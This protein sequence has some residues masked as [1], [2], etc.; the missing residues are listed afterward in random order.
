[1]SADVAVPM[2]SATLAT[3]NGTTTPVPA[4]FVA[5]I[6]TS[7][8]CEVAAAKRDDLVVILAVELASS[9][10]APPPGFEQIDAHT[11]SVESPRIGRYIV[12]AIRLKVG[13]GEVAGLAVVPSLAWPIYEAGGFYLR[14]ALDV[15][16]AAWQARRD[17]RRARA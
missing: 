9:D 2:L 17:A 14:G 12:Q 8:Y 5:D 16:L 15:D 4:L 1:M 3:V 7:T 10:G 13:D 6:L 11:F